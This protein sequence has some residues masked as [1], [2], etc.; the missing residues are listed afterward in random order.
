MT[1]AVDEYKSQKVFVVG[2]VRTPGTYPLSGD[3]NLVE[4]LA[5]AGSTLPTAS[6]EVVIV[7]PVS[8]RPAGRCCRRRRTPAN[9]V[10]VDISGRCRTA[11]CLQNAALRRRRHNLRAA[12]GKRLRVRPGEEPRR[13]RAAAA[14]TR[15][16]CRRS[17]S[18]AASPTGARPRRIRI[19]RIVDGEKQEIKVK[20]SDLVQPGD[21]VMVQERFF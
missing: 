13:L 1:V 2:E 11:C 6:G 7:H 4:A 8:G 9:I 17:R 19:V 14:G 12:G 16:C 5:R 10:R 18:P 15:P 20:L 21:T 3:M